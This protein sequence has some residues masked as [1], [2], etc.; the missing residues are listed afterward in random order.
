MGK[1]EARTNCFSKRPPADCQ[2]AANSL[3]CSC[4]SSRPLTSQSAPWF[5]LNLRT[6]RLLVESIAYHYAVA[7]HQADLLG[8][9]NIRERISFHRDDVRQLA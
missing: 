9:G 5:P 4:S 7:E 2:L 3:G 8:E 1:T 6:Q